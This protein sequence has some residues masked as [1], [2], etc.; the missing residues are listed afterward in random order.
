MKIYVTSDLE[1]ISGI[2]AAE[3]V[4]PSGADYGEGRRYLTEEINA[5]VRGCFEGG[6]AEVVVADRHSGGRNVVWDLLDDRASYVV[7]PGPNDPDG[8]LPGIQGFD[9]LI[10]LGYH[11]RHGTH[12]AVL[13]HTWSSTGWH[14]FWING[15]PSGELALDAAFAADFGVPAIMASGDDKLCAEAA[16]L[17]PGIVTAQVKEGYAR[18]GAKLLSKGA[19][20]ALVAKQSAEAVR[21]CKSIKPFAVSKPVTL[22]LECVERARA[23]SAIDRPF[24]K[25]LDERTFEVT[26][27]TF[28]QAFYRLGMVE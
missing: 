16:A 18:Y 7:G 2:V 28:R 9:G 25:I 21:R 12:G 15:Q 13:R 26:G 4:S 23:P 10:L 14:N 6:A 19:A 3:Q 22:R 5:C 24:A 20:H 17:I 8:R 11:A 27:D 1:G